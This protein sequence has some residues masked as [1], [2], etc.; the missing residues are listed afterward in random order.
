MFKKVDQKQSFPKLEEE[1]LQYWKDNKL[2]EKSV[3]S[4]PKSNEYVF[5]DGPPFAN[6]LPHYGHL[7]AS[8][9]KDV[10]PR[11]KTM[12]GFRVER[13]FGWDTHGLPVETLAEKELKI[14]SKKEIVE[15]GIDKF[16]EYCRTSV[17]RYVADWEKFI[18]RV[19]RWVDFKNNYK[20]LDLNYMESV[21]WV[22]K[23][24]YDKNL[25]YKGPR[26]SFYCT[27]CETPLSNF[28]ISMDNSYQQ[29]QDPSI[30][31]KFTLKTGNEKVGVK[32]DGKT[33]ILAW[34]TTPWT[35]P[36]NEALAIKE[37]IHYVQVEA[38]SD[39]Y[40]L[41][42]DRLAS[43]KEILGEHKILNEF[44]GKELVGLEYEPLFDYFKDKV[45]HFKVVAADFVSTEDGTGTVHIAPAYGEEDFNLGKRVG[46]PL[47]VNPLNSNGTFSAAVKDFEGIF[48]K[49]ANKVIASDLKDRGKV[50]HLGTIDHSVGICWRCSTPLIYMA[51]DAWFVK[52]S[53]IK[54]QAVKQNEKITWVPE[55][56]KHGRFG[57]GLE[58]APDWNITRNRFWGAPIPIWQCEKCHE[59]KVFGSIAEIEKASGK[60]VRDLHRPMIDE[61]TVPCDQC[62]GGIMKRVSE[63]LDCWFE[64]GSMPYAVAHYPFENKKWFKENFPADFIA[65][66]IAQTRGWFYNLH[67][68]STALFKKPAFKAAVTTGTILAEDGRKMSK[69][70]KNYPDPYFIFEKYGADALRFYLMASPVMRAE[71]FNFAERGVEDVVRQVILPLWNAYGF[72]VTYANID[73]W[74]PG[75]L[76]KKFSHQLDRWI[77]SELNTT[78]KK[79]T[80]QMDAYDTVS[81]CATLASF[82]DGLTN[83]YIRRSRRRFWKSE[84]DADKNEAYATLYHV[85]MTYIKLIAPFTPFVSESI[86]RNLND[87]ESVHL[88]DWPKVEKKFIDEDLN[89]E[90]E[91]LRR[92]VRLG[93]A[94]RAKAKVKVRQPLAKVEIAATEKEMAM[95]QKD[96]NILLSEI[97]VKKLVVLKETPKT[98]TVT[99][100]PNARV[101]GPKFGKDIQFIIKNAKAGNFTVT[102]SGYEVTD[103]TS[104]QKWEVGKA[105][106]ELRYESGENEAVEAEA[107]MVVVLDT[108]ITAEL[109]EEGIAREIVRAVQ[110]LRKASGLEVDNRIELQIKAGEKVADAV[111]SFQK[112]I[113]AE[114]LADKL[115]H[116]DPK[117]EFQSTLKI[118][119]LEITFGIRKI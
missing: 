100:S 50:L 113:M 101:L 98:I 24:L 42:M 40:I 89:I 104:K 82:L 87:A 114:T 34:T 112:Y 8:I 38:G 23:T 63:V 110:D 65:E 106:A 70:L 39:K 33:H 36:S 64:S 9:I 59:E 21:L 22:F 102:K 2:F 46:L 107:G 85:L 20:T 6:G 7:L 96:E 58:T 45:K 90:M 32:A 60:K 15:Y 75:K 16:N 117:T 108:E 12:Q 30:T 52:V 79:V 99:L 41:A 53:H 66:Y 91:T 81:A 27:R 97:N 94:A 18:D 69:S 55:H 61:I 105:E 76:P 29:M 3:S 43:Y 119:G 11:Y 4:R 83:W 49:D 80:E 47:D 5:Y 19:G 10:V 28:E 51:Q 17:L 31:V 78:I 111:Q 84:D 67:V 35:L 68:I 62:D 115:V 118:E 72:F 54:E 44:H 95:L 88:A 93:L 56:L 37:D 1:I 116:D 71:N 103:P 86:F 92:A 13:R 25:I 77:L 109:Q 14:K 48:Y 73:G 74:K 57:K 26:T